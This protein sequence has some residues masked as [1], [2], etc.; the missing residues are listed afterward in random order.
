MIKIHDN[1]YISEENIAMVTRDSYSGEA[2]VLFKQPIK[3]V[4][5]HI[6]VIEGKEVIKEKTTSIPSISIEAA[7]TEELFLSLEAIA[8]GPL[9]DEEWLCE[10]VSKVK[11][12]DYN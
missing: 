1:L 10:K 6:E 4:E 9:E 3:L 11:D 12:E 8:L 5:E 2:V 7:Y